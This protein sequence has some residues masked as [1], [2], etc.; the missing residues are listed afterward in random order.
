MK[1][2]YKL[3]VFD[4]DGTLTKERSLWEFIHKS[5]GKWYNLAINYQDQFLNNEISYEEFCRLDA[6]IWKGMSVRRLK[7]IVKSVPFYDGIGSLTSYLKSYNIKLSVISSGLSIL[8]DIVKK[9]YGFDY[10]VANELIYNN[11]TLAGEVNINVCFDEKAKWVKKIMR[12]Y[13]VRENE[14][15][16]I[17]DSMGDKEMFEI[18]GFSVAFNPSCN[19]LGRIVDVVVN[20]NDISDIVKKLPF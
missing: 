3:A 1:C 9:R 10:A 18:A 14:V 11:G 19:E 6:Q 15:I 13:K 17:G 16:A 12:K 20:G 7:N 8:S 4:L 5:V 2:N